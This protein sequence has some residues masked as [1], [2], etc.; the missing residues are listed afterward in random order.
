MITA[1][2]SNWADF[3]NK[4]TSRSM[5]PQWYERVKGQPLNNQYKIFAQDGF[6]MFGWTLDKDGGADV[7]DFEN[8]YKNNWNS[9]LEYRDGSGLIRFHTSPRP[10]NTTTYFSGAGDTG[11][12]GNGSRLLFNMLATDTSKQVELTYSE[13]VWIKDGSIVYKDAPLGSYIDIEVVHPTSGVVGSFGKKIL[14]LGTNI[15]Y[16][17]TEDSAEI[18]TGLKLRITVH[19]SSGGSEDAAAAF[20]VVGNIEYYRTTTI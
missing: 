18:A 17:N 6:L 7:T 2:V 4:V 19:N 15:A 13:K 10:E 11:G 5:K 8:N 20:K 1:E 16:L 14:L 12:I 3:K 9:K